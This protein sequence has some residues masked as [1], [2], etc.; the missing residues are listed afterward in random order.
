MVISISYVS[1]QLNSHQAKLKRLNRERLELHLDGWVRLEYGGNEIQLRRKGLA[2]LCYLALEGPTEREYL[3]DLLWGSGASSSNLRVELHRLRQA[4]SGLSFELFKDRQDPLRL[5]KRLK[6]VSPRKRRD[7]LEILRGMDD[8]SLQ[9]QEW[10]EFKRT[11]LSDSNTF[12]VREALVDDIAAAL[13]FPF[14][15]IVQGQ[16]ET[17]RL[18]FAQALA[19]Q[20]KVPFIS[21]EHGNIKGVRYVSTS[22]NRSENLLKQILSDQDNIW[23]IECSAFGEDSEFVLELRGYYQPDKMRFVQLKNLSW[24]ASRKT[25]LQA[26]S[27]REAATLYLASGGHPGYMAELLALRSAHDVTHLPLPQKIRAAYQLES[28]TLSQ[29]SRY[30]LERLSVHPG[31]LSEGLLEAFDAKASLDELERYG[32]LSFDN[33]WRFVNNVVRT[34][35]HESLPSGQRQR[36]HLTAAQTF[37]R[38][39]KVAAQYYHCQQVNQTS[40]PAALLNHVDDWA[41]RVLVAD[42]QASAQLRQQTYSLGEEQALLENSLSGEEVSFDDSRLVIVRNSLLP[43]LTKV[44]F[45]VL[46]R[47]QILKVSANLHLK[48]A[49]DI[50]L[51]GTAFPLRIKLIGEETQTVYFAA[52]S[53]SEK[54]DAFTYLLPIETTLSLYLSCPTFSEL[55]VESAATDAIIELDLRCYAKAKKGEAVTAYDLD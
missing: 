17:G 13:S 35:L 28:R 33:G 45:E 55:H 25:L 42:M 48:N 16:P 18:A 23:I 15:L 9:Y 19:K 8:I 46:E 30:A 27:F 5:S 6:I 44:E 39:N 38:E 21:G 51:S 41:K 37:E 26:L 32:W 24:H 4:L 12:L 50:G 34:I 22:V 2:L 49:H 54:L 29:G 11:D 43:T 10:L 36:Y 31:V 53:S 40:S 52:V 20:L 1:G 7:S 47:A 14:L 3:T